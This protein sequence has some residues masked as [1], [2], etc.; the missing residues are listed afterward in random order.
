MN[1]PDDVWAAASAYE[2]YIGRWSRLV[3][4]AF[5]EWLAAPP[6]ARWLDI[7]C[8]TGALTSTVLATA[9]PDHVCSVDGSRAYVAFARG[10][11]A[12]VRAT[13]AVADARQL[14]LP[15]AST[16]TVVS[17]LVLNFIPQP[18]LAIAEMARVVRSGG[19][20][21]LY[22]WDYADKMQ[23]IRHFWDAAIALDAGAAPLDEGRRFPVCQPRKL[24]QLFE[25]AGLKGVDSRAI[26][27]PTRF[28]DFTDY[29][30]PFL[31][32]QGPAPGYAMSLDGDERAR[33]RDHLRA[34]LPATA[35][36]SIELIARAWAV[37]GRKP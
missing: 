13:F 9:A 21:G 15:A 12:D 10:D 34:Q 25:A 31:G 22:V 33:L 32:G 4:R 27:V 11:I 35:D 24:E 7:G 17:G 20:V 19:I 30:T 5:V 2:P 26:D 36:G 14:P 1:P 28:R 8:G 3:A 6:A 29:W 16:D 23:L 18:E 37:R